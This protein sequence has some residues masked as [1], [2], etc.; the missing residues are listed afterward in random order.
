MLQ[1][2]SK[3]ELKFYCPRDPPSVLLDSIYIHQKSKV[4][5][6]KWTLHAQP[7]K[8]FLKVKQETTFDKLLLWV[9]VPNLHYEKKVV[10]RYTTDHWKTCQ[11]VQGSYVESYTDLS[12]NHESDLFL[13]RMD[14]PDTHFVQLEYCISY[15]YGDTTH[16]ENNE[17]RNHLLQ[18][19][20]KQVMKIKKSVRCVNFMPVN[21]MD[22]RRLP[23][24]TAIL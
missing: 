1:F 22:L 8:G 21:G 10:L 2:A 16:W 7:I 6:K 20:K 23:F 9:Q 24:R 12:S 15:Q 19:F 17:G 3:V 13:I 14:L 11:D 18:A 4:E 5:Q